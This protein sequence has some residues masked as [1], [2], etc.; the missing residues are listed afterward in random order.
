L[1]IV[2]QLFEQKKIKHENFAYI[3]IK[4]RDFTPVERQNAHTGQLTWDYELMMHDL[5]V[6]GSNRVLGKFQA[7]I[8]FRIVNMQ[9]SV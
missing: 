9:Q 7:V 8:N 1:T 4:L 6:I 5:P 3:N 2:V